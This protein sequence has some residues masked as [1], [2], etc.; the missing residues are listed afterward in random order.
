MRTL[1]PLLVLALL[2]GA[3]VVTVIA[4]CPQRECELSRNCPV[5]EICTADGR[6]EPST[7]PP[8]GPPIDAGP[9]GPRPDGGPDADGGPNEILRVPLVEQLNAPVTAILVDPQ[10]AATALVATWSGGGALDE[11]GELDIAGHQMSSSPRFDFNNISGGCDVDE[12]HWFADQ[13]PLQLPQGHELWFSCAVGGGAVL[14]YT[15]LEF[16]R[17]YRD[18]ALDQIDLV[19][20]VDSGEDTNGDARVVFA[21]R[22]GNELKVVRFEPTDQESAARGLEDVGDDVELDAIAG[23]WTVIES[24]TRMGDVVLVFDRGGGGALPRLVPVQRNYGELTW[25]GPP[26]TN[27]DLEIITLPAATH[28]VLFR[29]DPGIPDPHQL[30]TDQAD[31]DIPNVLVTMPTEGNGGRALFFRYERENGRDLAATPPTS[32]FP[33]VS[34]GGTNMPSTVPGASAKLF[35]RETTVGDVGFAYVLPTAACGFWIPLPGDQAD[36]VTN[37]VGRGAFQSYTDTPSAV[38]PLSSTRMLIGFSNRS[39]IHQVGFSPDF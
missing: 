36:D 15:N 39:E 11:V 10:D 29:E 35:L 33:E 14:H 31:E 20:F 3:I 5:G 6:C 18:S 30:T 1:S 37:D 28:G 27:S 17:S 9:L 21:E 24:D 23:L 34:L 13:G 8:D 22:G 25:H 2:V 32:G 7:T 16:A 4:A 26:I 38:V 19:T 12:M